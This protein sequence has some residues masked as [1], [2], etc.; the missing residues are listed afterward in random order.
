MGEREGRV[1]GAGREGGRRDQQF[2]GIGSESERGRAGEGRERLRTG[3][4]S[5]A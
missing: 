3:E 1:R 4:I 5:G 2:T